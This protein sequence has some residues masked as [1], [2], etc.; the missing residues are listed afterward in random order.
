MNVNNQ[1]VALTFFLELELGRGTKTEVENMRL[2]FE[3]AKKL[4]DLT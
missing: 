3:Y 4:E 1:L 2:F